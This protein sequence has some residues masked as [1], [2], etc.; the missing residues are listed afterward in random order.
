MENPNATWNDFSTRIFQKD[1]S[2][3][4]SCNFL[5]NEEQTKT[6]MATPGQEI[7]NPRSELQEHRVDAVEGKP[8]TVNPNQKGRQNAHRFCNYCPRKGHTASLCRKKIRDEEVK[9]IENERTLQKKFTFTQYYKKKRG[10]VH[11]SEQW[12]RGQDIQRRN[13]NYN[14]DRPTRVFPTCC[15]KFFLIPNFA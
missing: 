3:Q 6:Q 7:K 2:S 9:S 8:P 4:V 12:K 13:N 14:N 1:V 15:Q 11:G 5:N 10:P